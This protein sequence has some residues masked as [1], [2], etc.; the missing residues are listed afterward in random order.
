MRRTFA[1]SLFAALLLLP[2][3]AAGAA[4][5]DDAAESSQTIEVAW[6]MPGPFQGYATFPQTY[7]PGGVP[8]CGP[9]GVQVD[10][11]KYGTPEVRALVDALL[12]GGVLNSPADDARVSAGR[13]HWFVDLEPCTPDGPD[14][15]GEPTPPPGTDVESGGGGPGTSVKVLPAAGA[16]PVVVAL[17]R[18]AG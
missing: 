16:A 11:Y 17:P 5:S 8:E 6:M 3:T 2:A 12:A 7:L 10:V 15:P 1:A 14:D 4:P 13:Q 18:Y 9:G